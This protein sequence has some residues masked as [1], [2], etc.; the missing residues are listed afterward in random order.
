MDYLPNIGPAFDVLSIAAARI[1]QG[2]GLPTLVLP[3][4]EK[5]NN[6]DLANFLSSHP[7]SDSTRRTYRDVLSRIC[8]HSP[9]LAQMSAP[10]LLTRL[11]QSGWGNARQCLALAAVQKFLEWKYGQS[12]PALTA[13]IKRI[14]GKQQRSLTPEIALKLLA[15]FN[16]YAP[17]GARDLAICS[18]ALD[19]GLRES[20]L[21]RLQL[22]DTDLEHRVLQVI[23]KGG[24]WS[25]AIFGANTA[26]HIERWLH[27]RKIADGKNNLFTHIKTGKPLT[28][29]GL[30]TIV[31]EWG[32]TI[33]I[34]LSPHDLR[35]SM[36]VMALLNGASDRTIMEMGRWK[37]PAMIVRYT[38][39]LRLE[40]LRGYLAT[41]RLMG[42]K[43]AFEGNGE[44]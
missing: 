16:P 24:Q 18:L 44:V 21:C 39:S 20:E 38:R 19:T 15:S 34:Q 22:A 25:A 30:Y 4:E 31:R 33:G 17:K 8:A 14:Q 2:R 1:A 23:I 32:W 41:D 42:E 43:P 9:D 26:A 40:Q 28:P 6:D 3:F 13:K 36:A 5:M 27:Y 37:N 10:E 29:E 12:H 7:Y 35:R 11:K